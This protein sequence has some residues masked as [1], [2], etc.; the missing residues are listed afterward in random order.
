VSTLCSFFSPRWEDGAR[1]F[2][3]IR[4]ALLWLWL[5]RCS[6]TNCYCGPDDS[7]TCFVTALGRMQ[8]MFVWR[9]WVAGK[10]VRRS[11]EG[12]GR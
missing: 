12:D 3:S 11:Q 8:R 6:G 10:L 5:L 4:A 2:R 7:K 1:L 9:R